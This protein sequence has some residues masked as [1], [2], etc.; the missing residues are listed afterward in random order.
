MST[1]QP[2]RGAAPAGALGYP[3][4]TMRRP[5]RRWG[6]YTLSLAAASVLLLVTAGGTVAASPGLRHQLSLKL[7]TARYLTLSWW[8]GLRPHPIVLPAPEPDYLSPS[9]PLAL[10]VGKRPEAGLEAAPAAEAPAAVAPEPT[11]VLTGALEARQPAAPAAEPEPAVEPL[12]AV[13]AQEPPTVAPPAAQADPEASS[14]L[15]AVQLTGLTHEY[16]RWNNCGPATLAM[17]LNYLGESLTQYDTAPLIKGHADDKNTSPGELAAYAR[18]RGWGAVVR[19]NGSLELLQKLLSNGFPVMVESWFAAGRP[20]N[21]VGHYRLLTGY[22]LSQQV[23]VSQD[24]YN[25]PGYR[26]SFQEQDRLWRYFNRTYLVVYDPAD[27]P[28]LQAVLGEHWDPLRALEDGVARSQAEVEASPEDPQSWF[29]LGT[30]LAGVGRHQEAAQAYDRARALGLH[31]RTLWYQFGP[32][33]AYLAVGRYQDVLDLAQAS[34][35]TARVHEE[36][37]YWMGR[38]LLALGRVEEARQAFELA[39]RDNPRFTPAEEALR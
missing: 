20:D 29:N 37:R 23:F 33:E 8:Y 32:Y 3:E 30:N 2:G 19:Q 9:E 26:L 1:G 4:G 27:E 28:L 12:P 17:Q 13:P 5:R 31:F 36:S 24:S 25:G 21:E 16:Q 35:Q 39:L 18:E 6:R 7:E 22:D 10:Q 38:A 11:D 14:I 34:L 15:P